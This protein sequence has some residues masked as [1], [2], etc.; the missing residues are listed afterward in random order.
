L[1]FA[2]DAHEEKLALGTADGRISIIAVDELLARGAAQ[3]WVEIG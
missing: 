1:V 3:D 2:L